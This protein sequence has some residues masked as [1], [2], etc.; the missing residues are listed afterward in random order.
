MASKNYPANPLQP[1]P[2]VKEWPAK[3]LKSPQKLPGQTSKKS[4]NK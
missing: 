3:V 1:K 2:V 4:P